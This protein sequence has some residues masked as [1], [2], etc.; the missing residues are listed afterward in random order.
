MNAAWHRC[1][2]SLRD[3]GYEMSYLLT[4]LLTYLFADPAVTQGRERRLMRWNIGWTV[5][6]RME[7]FG[8]IKTSNMHCQRSGATIVGTGEHWS[9]NFR[10]AD[11][12][13]IGP[14]NFLAVV[15][16][17]QEILQQVVTRMPDLAS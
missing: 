15:F 10:L 3:S 11:Q 4:H 14:P 13:C 17:K 6:A 16:K 12:Q 7:I 9:L 8:I 2:V 1:G 5:V